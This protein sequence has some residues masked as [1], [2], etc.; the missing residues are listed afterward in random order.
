MNT[1]DIID[2]LGEISDSLLLQADLTVR[3]RSYPRSLAIVAA[4]VLMVCLF[5][6]PLVFDIVPD[7]VSDLDDSFFGNG[8]PSLPS[9]TSS[10]IGNNSNTVQDTEPELSITDESSLLDSSQEEMI[11]PFNSQE[12][13]DPQCSQGNLLSPSDSSSDS[14]EGNSSYSAEGDSDTTVSPEEPS[15]EVPDEE[16]PEKSLTF[17]IYSVNADLPDGDITTESVTPDYIGTLGPSDSETLM[18][19]V[20]SVTVSENKAE[21]PSGSESA[22]DSPFVQIDILV[23]NLGYDP[24]YINLFKP[25]DGTDLIY[26]YRSCEGESYLL[27]RGDSLYR[28]SAQRFEVIMGVAIGAE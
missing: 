12:G 23:E 20:E 6:V 7:P 4:A 15:L 22:P 21:L 10:H 2:S 9:E 1:E 11:P 24:M 14:S 26:I 25:S 13:S 8:S 5:T 16:C 28:L 19:L 27:R 17:E 18:S 3:R